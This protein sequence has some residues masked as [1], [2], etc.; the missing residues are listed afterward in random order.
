MI[1][2]TL[3]WY[4]WAMAATVGLMRHAEALRCGR[5][6]AHGLSDEDGSALH[7]AGACG[8]LAFAKWRGVFWPGGINTFKNTDVGKVQ[9]RTRSKEDYDLIVRDGDADD[10]A[11]VLVVG[12]GVSYGIVGWLWGREAKRPEW[13]KCY[14]RRRPAYFVP[15]AALHPMEELP[16]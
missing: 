13:S 7:I 6:N 16:R 5:R 4:E 14:G 2:V 12:T 1:E 11:F 10:E 15:Q 8:E 3:E 9:V